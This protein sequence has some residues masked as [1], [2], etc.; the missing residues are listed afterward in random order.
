MIEKYNLYYILS[1]VLTC[2]CAILPPVGDT[3][4]KLEVG[5]CPS[6]DRDRSVQGRPR[7]Q[8]PER[9]AQDGNK[10][11]RQHLVR[12]VQT[13][14]GFHLEY[15][16]HPARNTSL[17]GVLCGDNTILWISKLCSCV[18][19]RYVMFLDPVFVKRH[20]TVRTRTDR[21]FHFTIKHREKLKTNPLTDCVCQKAF[22]SLLTDKQDKQ[23]K[24]TTT[25]RTDTSRRTNK[26][27]RSVKVRKC[28]ASI[29]FKL[30]F[31]S[32]PLSMEKK[33]QKAFEFCFQKNI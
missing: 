22:Y 10:T 17:K 25:I 11:L 28:H 29:S 9:H 23:N 30:F 6:P 2:L 15:H 8:V 32:T 13:P 24:Q 4:F 27:E 14:G 18:S 12:Q 26:R 19:V 31:E 5:R 3:V 21:R 1:C 33:S 20:S 16:R 7:H